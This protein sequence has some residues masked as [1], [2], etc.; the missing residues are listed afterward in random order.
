MRRAR[1]STG[2]RWGGLP[3][4]RVPDGGCR[5][6]ASPHAVDLRHRDASGQQLLDAPDAGD[7]A[8]A[9]E[10]VSMRGALRTHQPVATLPGAQACSVDAGLRAQV[11]DGVE[12]FLFRGLFR[13]VGLADAGA[14]RAGHDGQIVQW[15]YLSRTP[16][17]WNHCRPRRVSRRSMHASG[18]EA[19]WCPQGVGWCG[20]LVWL[21]CWHC[22]GCN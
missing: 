15:R 5:L 1:G 2:F 19:A 20:G 12:P 22:S 8:D 3:R 10:S 11:T 16:R 7:V 9:V 6:L 21:W 18:R 14:S 17:R 13:G 4:F